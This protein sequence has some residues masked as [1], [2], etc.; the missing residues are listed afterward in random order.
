MSDGVMILLIFAIIFGGSGAVIAIV[1]FAAKK[2]RD[3]KKIKCTKRADGI[4]TN[5]V[6]RGADHAST[7]CVEYVV[8]G[9][10]YEVKDSLK[11]KKSTIKVGNVPVGQHTRSVLEDT[12]IGAPV[13]VYYEEGNPQHAYIAGNDG[14]ITS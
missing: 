6:N 3:K 8:N 1:L 14:S 10:R 5:I 7:I 9:V 2:G 11:M 4:I 12:R 13:D